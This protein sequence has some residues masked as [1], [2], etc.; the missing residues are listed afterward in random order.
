MPWHE[1]T[2]LLKVTNQPGVHHVPAPPSFPRGAVTHGLWSNDGGMSC[3]EAG[4][5]KG[6]VVITQHLSSENL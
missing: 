1:S 2:L 4:R 6:W 3:G 5:V